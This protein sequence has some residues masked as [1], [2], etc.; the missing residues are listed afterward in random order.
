MWLQHNKASEHYSLQFSNYPNIIFP[1]RWITRGGPS[2]CEPDLTKLN[3]ASG[4]YFI[5][6]H[7]LF[8]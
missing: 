1:D 8:C 6:L 7:I 2:L 3:F 5:L 4:L